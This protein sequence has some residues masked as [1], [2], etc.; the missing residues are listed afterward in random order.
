M[1]GFAPLI[2]A[3]NAARLKYPAA[4]IFV[5]IKSSNTNTWRYLYAAFEQI[6][7]M[8]FWLLLPFISGT[9]QEQVIPCQPFSDKVL[10]TLNADSN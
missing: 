7:C 8:C 10:A 5:K 3:T 2:K 4:L 9:Q 6:L 1:N